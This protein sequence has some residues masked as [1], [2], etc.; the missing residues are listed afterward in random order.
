MLTNAFTDFSALCEYD[1]VTGKITHLVS[2]APDAVVPMHW[3][4]EGFECVGD[5]IFVTVNEDGWTKLYDVVDG[6][7][8]P[9]AA[10]FYGV[11]SN[12]PH[13]PLSFKSDSTIATFQAV[14]A[15]L[16]RSLFAYDF[17]TAVPTASPVLLAAKHNLEITNPTNIHCTSPDGVD[18]PALVYATDK[19]RARTD[20]S[21]PV[22]VYLHP[23]PQWQ[24]R[25]RFLPDYDI[26]VSTQFFLNEMGA[27]V[28]APNTRGSP[29][30]GRSFLASRP[31]FERYEG[32]VID[33]GAI[34]DWI[35][36]QPFLDSKRVCFMGVSYGSGLSLMAAATYPDR[37]RCCIDTFGVSSVRKLFES[38]NQ[39]TVNRYRNA[40]GDERDPEIHKRLVS[41]SP[42][43]HV[44]KMRSPLLI[45]HGDKDMVIP[46][47]QSISMA[48]AAHQHGLP[49]WLM[50]AE[51]EG[52]SFTK[53][54]VRTQYASC[55]LQFMESYFVDGIN[56][57]EGADSATHAASV[58]HGVT[59]SEDEPV[60]DK[61]R[62]GIAR[63]FGCTK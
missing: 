29:G 46:I 60:A 19:M 7:A 27:A 4:V 50:V 34:L 12:F 21:V 17:A 9:V 23:G 13:Q 55:I 48:N 30:Y 49:C 6:V 40:Y 53:P 8:N 32:S 11:I 2:S 28:I 33:I 45:A 61:K 20:S 56:K 58:L 24:S 35:D 39:S 42:L 37:I 16:P 26:P 44:D 59:V 38:D 51:G 57:T 25:P 63:L 15:G 22:I 62:G 43:S 14:T 18:V 10:S 41:I 3:D 47:S 5:H 31:P 1:L 52:H 36:Q 54:T